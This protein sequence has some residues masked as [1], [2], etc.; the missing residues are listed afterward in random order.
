MARGVTTPAPTQLPKVSFVK[1]QDDFLTQPTGVH[2]QQA[3]SYGYN[4]SS[5]FI[6]PEHYIR[7]IEPLESELLVQVEYDMDEQDQE[8]LDAV[9]ADRKKEQIDKVS[10]ETFEIIMDRLEKEWFDLTKNIP[11]PDLALPSE[12]STCAICDDSEGENTNAIVFCDGC[13][14]AVHQD[15]YG[16]PYIPEGQWLC[17]KCTVSP[18]NPVSCILCPNEGGAFKQT[19]DGDWVHLLCA[20]WVPETRVAN[21]VFME[22]ITGVDRISKSRWKLKCSICDVREG[23]CIQCNKPSCFLAFHATCAR[24]ERLLMPMKASQGSEAPQLAAYCE[25]HLP[26]EE[27]DIR[28]AALKAERAASNALDSD[29]EHTV[30]ASPK[31]SKT[32]RAYAKTYKPGPPL[33]PHIIVRRLLQYIARIN[34]RHKEKFVLMVCR[35]WSLKREARRGA[36]LLKRLHLEPWT[37]NGGSRHQSDEDK[38]VK[39]KYMKRVRNDLELLRMLSTMCISREKHKLQQGDAVRSIISHAFYPHEPSLRAAFERFTAADRHGYFRNPVSK[40]DVPDYYDVIKRPMCWHWIEQKIDGHEYWDLQDFKDD[41]YLVLNNAMLYNKAG[42]QFYKTAQNI[43]NKADSILADLDKHIQEHSEIDLSPPEEGPLSLFPPTSPLANLEPPISLLELLSVNDA[44]KDEI[45]LILSAPPLESLFTYE[46]PVFKPPP[47]P[48]PKKPSRKAKKQK[49]LDS[50]PGFRAPPRT[51]NAIA[52]AAAHEAEAQVVA[53]PSTTAEAAEVEM[54]EVAETAKKASKRGKRAPI[55]LPGQAETPP[56]VEDVDKQEQFKMFDKGWI[57]PPDHRRGGRAPVERGPVPPPRK[58]QRVGEREKSHVSAVSAV[59]VESET[60]RTRSRS[61]GADGF[62]PRSSV[63][64][65]SV[66]R[67][68][69]PRS[70]VPR[71]S[72][73]APDRVSSPTPVVEE[74]KA[75]EADVEASHAAIP[76]P[77]PSGPTEPPREPIHLASPAPQPPVESLGDV[78]MEQPSHIEMAQPVEEKPVEEP[79][80]EE[81]EPTPRKVI[82]IETLDTPATRREKYLRKREERRLAREAEE[83]AMAAR[84]TRSHATLE[85]G[86][87][88][89]GPSRLSVGTQERGVD[90][91]SELS[92]LSGLSDEEDEEMLIAATTREERTA[93]SKTPPQERPREPGVIR[94]GE[95][96]RL[97]GGTLVWAKSTGNPWWPAVVF[98]RDD[99]E[100]P[101]KLFDDPHSEDERFHLVRFFDQPR[102]W[103]W[104]TL[105]KLLLLHENQALDDDMLAVKS[106][107]QTW[108]SSARR[109]EVRKAYQSALAEMET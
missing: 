12:D 28:A 103:M 50:S 82:I 53:G 85:S 17:R 63:P 76:E 36:P 99:D 10:Y 57:L 23:A 44:I 38:A 65:S 72:V 91:L 109:S 41:I 45:D 94:L 42:T 74:S 58:R 54:A 104:A 78:G 7:Y 88:V 75:I 73:P 55:V 90:A 61:T 4:D 39:L 11:K 67:S 95:G 26:K 60:L 80:E 15:C 13:N 35:Y 101:E 97:E 30:V 87:P 18:E 51:R 59:A 56:M 79:E 1:V 108:K 106:K 48:K 62:G 46:F 34:L 22:P 16:V 107:R 93:T 25:R 37:A 21:E 9:N 92:S 64:R 98:E 81:E 31:S 77:F 102:S 33:V 100:I 66:P 6:R 96:E 47:P 52:Q 8:W 83:A 69:V 3:R 105:D 49:E 14:L 20:I 40:I 43:K 70:S 5:D 86:L 2:D 32:A 27:A 24:K 19:T 29:S 71:S 84:L 89:A 68:S